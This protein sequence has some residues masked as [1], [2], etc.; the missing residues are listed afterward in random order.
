MILDRTATQAVM[1]GFVI[2]R[3]SAW[4]DFLELFSVNMTNPLHF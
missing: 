1:F 3:L 2:Q 4:L